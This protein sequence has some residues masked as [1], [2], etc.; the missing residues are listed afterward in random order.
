[1]DLIAL[2]SSTL[3]SMNSPFSCL[4][5][6]LHDCTLTS[7][8]SIPPSLS[9][10]DIGEG[11]ISLGESGDGGGDIHSVKRWMTDWSD[12]GGASLGVIERGI[13]K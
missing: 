1:M 10:P 7:S 2:L 12:I 4:S 9:V 13:K 11:I 5:L 6:P 8:Q 3:F